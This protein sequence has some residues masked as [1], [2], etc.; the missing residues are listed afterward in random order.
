MRLI[1]LVFIIEM[2]FILS[3]IIPGINEIINEIIYKKARNK[4]RKEIRIENEKIEKEKFLK[5]LKRGY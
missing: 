2:L 4:I 1:D 5:E 3:I